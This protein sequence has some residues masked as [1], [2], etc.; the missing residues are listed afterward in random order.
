MFIWRLLASEPLSLSLYTSD[1]N[2]HCKNSPRQTVCTKGYRVDKLVRILQGLQDSGLNLY[3]QQE[4][5][6]H[7][8]IMLWASP[9]RSLPRVRLERSTQRCACNESTRF[10]VDK[11]LRVPRNLHFK[12]H[13]ARCLPRNLRIKIHITLPCQSESHQEHFQRQHQDAKA[14]LSLEM[15]SN[16]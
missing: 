12:V 14:Q 6:P 10:K 16:F 13:K 2:H 4:Y 5:G 1:V 9:S 3:A 11:A 7:L 15:S 8:R